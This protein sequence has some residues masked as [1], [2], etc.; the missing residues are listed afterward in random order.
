MQGWSGFF[1]FTENDRITCMLSGHTRFYFYVLEV[2]EVDLT[3]A[4]PVFYH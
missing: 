2:L 3:H 4:K 1:F